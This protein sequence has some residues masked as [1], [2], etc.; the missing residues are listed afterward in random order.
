MKK[1]AIL[2]CG[3][4]GLLAAHAAAMNDCDI[5]IFS[6]ARKSRL[7]G[8]QYLHQPIPDIVQWPERVSYSLVGGTV[9]EY[10]N[11]VYGGTWD[12]TSSPEELENHHTAYDI[13]S[14]YEGLWEMYEDCIVDT[15][16][17][18]EKQLDAD[19]NLDQF[20]MV[21]STIPRKIW[22]QP[23]DAFTS[24]KV[25]AFGEAP[26]LGRI[27]PFAPE[28]DF[29]IICDASKDVGWYRLSKVFGHT[30]I[31]WPSQTKPPMAGLVKVEKPLACKTKGAKYFHH[32]GRYGEWK[33]GVLTT[34][35]F[36]RAME[37]TR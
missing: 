26:E 5:Q 7:F 6:K 4:S 21:I 35:V 16:I 31:E 30:T 13:R 34:D 18:S 23:G 37:L 1:V 19:R 33:K 11:K 20:D 3:P 28:K 9:A 27:A 24:T 32:L 2:G 22:A 12:G 29:T 14:A 10:R 8:C 25:W 15:E 36:Y 17:V